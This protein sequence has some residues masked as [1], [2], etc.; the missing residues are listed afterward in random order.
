[1]TIFWS[2]RESFSTYNSRGA[3][4]SKDGEKSVQIA[5]G[6][7]LKNGF[8]NVDSYIV[9]AARASVLAEPS[10]RVAGPPTGTRRHPPHL[11]LSEQR[12]EF[13]LAIVDSLDLLRVNPLA[14]SGR[15]VVPFDNKFIWVDF[16]PLFLEKRFAF[17]LHAWR[18]KLVA[19]FVCS[20]NLL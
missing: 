11:P 14:R 15:E 7:A 10:F 9:E 17:I 19:W 8:S 16:A 4:T 13:L 12:H 6:E 3:L 1:M 2:P 18:R 20:G 5:S